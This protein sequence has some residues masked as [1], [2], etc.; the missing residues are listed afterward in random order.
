ML[1]KE[2]RT[3]QQRLLMQRT[4]QIRTIQRKLINSLARSLQQ[5]IWVAR[6]K[7][8]WHRSPNLIPNDK[9]QIWLTKRILTLKWMRTTLSTKVWAEW[10]LRKRILTTSSSKCCSLPLYLYLY[11]PKQAFDWPRGVM[12]VICPNRR[13]SPR[14]T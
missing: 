8:D 13:S 4:T 7:V 2:R 10:E 14:P 11:P 6:K 1:Q 5:P 9:W 3:I 12:T